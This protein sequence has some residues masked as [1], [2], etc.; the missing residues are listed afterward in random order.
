MEG[1]TCAERELTRQ[2]Q[3]AEGAASADSAGGE[4]D[5]CHPKPG[6]PRERGDLSSSPVGLAK[7][8]DLDPLPP[9]RHHAAGPYACPDAVRWAD[10]DRPRPDLP[11]SFRSERGTIPI[12]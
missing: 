1:R 12:A 2:S 10:L 11:W 9:R 6:S 3:A 4:A 5:P 8:T 7:A